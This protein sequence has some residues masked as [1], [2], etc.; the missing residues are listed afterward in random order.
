MV[1][2]HVFASEQVLSKSE[3]APGPAFLKGEERF[4]TDL[5]E[6]EA[7]GLVTA[8]RLESAFGC[9]VQLLSQLH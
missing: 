5:T 6:L 7:A 8:Y 9:V 1:D 4:R 3:R 2:S